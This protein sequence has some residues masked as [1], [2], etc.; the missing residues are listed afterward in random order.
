MVEKTTVN[1]KGQK[2]K[3]PKKYIGNL[4]GEEKNKQVASIMEGKKRPKTSAPVKRSSL[5]VRFQKKYGV[6]ITN[7]SYISKN[8]I[9]QTGINK[10][11]SK[12]RGAYFS[13]GSRPNVSAEQWARS[14]L[15]GVILNS[16]ARKVDIDI[17]NKYKK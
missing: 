14:R 13:S 10:I 4:K 11:L 6:P 12:G 17:W 3:I 7:D 1:Y 16:P 8:I 9:S 2:K 5:V 15:A